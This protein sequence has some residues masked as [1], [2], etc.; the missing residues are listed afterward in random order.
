MEC[1]REKKMRYNCRSSLAQ[2][3]SLGFFKFG[4]FCR[5]FFLWGGGRWGPECLYKELKQSLAI[6]GGTNHIFEH[7]KTCLLKCDVKRSNK[8]ISHQRNAFTGFNHIK[9]LSMKGNEDHQP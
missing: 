2:D 6:D 3:K 1:D 8:N 7:T 9:S 5:F 4:G